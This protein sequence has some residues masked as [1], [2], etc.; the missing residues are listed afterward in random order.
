MRLRE[1]VAVI[2]GGSRGIGREIVSA[3]AREGARVAFSYLR[4]DDAAR[5]LVSSLQA[6]GADAFAVRADAASPDETR[7]LAEEARTRFGRIDI[8][9]NNAGADILTAPNCNLPTLDQLDLLLRVD[10]RGTVSGCAIAAEVMD[11]QGRGKII[12]IAWD[13]IYHGLGT[14]QGELY[15]LAKAAVWAYSR[16]LARR[17]APA[18]TVNVIAPGW[19]ET[20]WGRGL[21]ADTHERIARETP[22]GRWGQPADVAAAAVFLASPDADFITGQTLVVNGG[23]VMP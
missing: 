15:A 12:N 10:V 3:F 23:T 13:H 7:A 6:L 17:L 1:R 14:P 5:H 9:I 16:S 4:S 8:W 20:T 2:T 11:R 18:I 19:I 22:L 21:D